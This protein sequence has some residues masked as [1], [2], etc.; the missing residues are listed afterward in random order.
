MALTSKFGK[1]ARAGLKTAPLPQHAHRLLRAS[2]RWRPLLA[3]P[4]GSL[5]PWLQS[6]QPL[7]FVH[8]PL[9]GLLARLASPLPLSRTKSALTPQPPPPVRGR[10]GA[11][12]EIRAVSATG[13]PVGR[14]A[15]P[16]RAPA[17]P[18]LSRTGRGGWGVRA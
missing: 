16:F 8:T 2:A 12:G 7:A 15:G 10:G 9:A 17:S 4:G 6:W 14:F 1:A 18:P 11:A 13:R 3:A 5:T